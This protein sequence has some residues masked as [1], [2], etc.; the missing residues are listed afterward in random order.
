MSP[1]QR[2][3]RR[4]G[5]QYLADEDAAANDWDDE[6]AALH[7]PEVLPVAPAH[8]VRVQPTRPHHL[9]RTET[10]FG[11]RPALS[12]P[13]Q[14]SRLARRRAV[15]RCTDLFSRYTGWST[16]GRREVSRPGPETVAFPVNLGVRSMVEEAV[17]ALS[18][19]RRI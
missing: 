1:S 3:L 10:A 12:E 14:Q 5:F 11:P 7:A 15:W 17:A 4:V 8:R 9:T 18:A 13:M 16:R 2:W 6:V 19:Q